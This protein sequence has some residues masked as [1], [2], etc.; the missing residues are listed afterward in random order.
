MLKA[1]ANNLDGCSAAA[2]YQPLLRLDQHL[3]PLALQRIAN[4]RRGCQGLARSALPVVCFPRSAALHHP[5][6]RAVGLHV[7]PLVQLR[8]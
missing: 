7:E 6:L 1:G 3:H 4:L 5:Q 2:I 8:H